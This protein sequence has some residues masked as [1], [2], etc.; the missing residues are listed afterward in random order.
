MTAAAESG[1]QCECIRTDALD[2]SEGHLF[3]MLVMLDASASIRYKGRHFPI[4]GS[5]VHARLLSVFLSE[6]L[7]SSSHQYTSWHMSCV[8]SGSS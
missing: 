1:F 7:E 5:L 2:V 8:S 6:R 4:N 3:L